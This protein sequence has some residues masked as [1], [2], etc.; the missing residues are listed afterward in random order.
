MI[1]ADDLI[2][3]VLRGDAAALERLL[4]SVQDQVYNMALRMLW[5]PADAADA[6]QEILIR[7]VTHL[8]GFQRRCAFSTWV[9]RIASNYLL[10]T[11]KR[12][13]E[14][15]E[16]TFEL[17]AAELQIGSQDLPSTL[18]PEEALLVQEIKVGCTHAML[19][20]LDRDQRLAYILGEIF[21]LPATEAAAVLEIAPE[22]FRKRLSRARERIG[23]FMSE[24]C[25]L[26]RAEN[27]C[28]CPRR[29]ARA[30]SR[31]RIHPDR[32]LFVGQPQAQRDRPN[33]DPRAAQEEM[34]SFV[35]AAEA[36]RANPWYA[37]PR[38]RIRA[39]RSLLE[40][41]DYHLLRSSD[42]E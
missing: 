36:L 9:Y 15:E 4:L 21:Q 7:V 29:I 11:R 38:D 18:G 40:S 20:C 25:G 22:A 35:A 14:Q 17:F 42:H 37:V 39:L 10:T 31:G 26:A 1:C 12:R 24:H 3:D 19:L 5:H 6:T 30:K 2:D 27:G 41:L 33:P 23:S 32:L 8:D 13:A 16:A 28:R 34:E